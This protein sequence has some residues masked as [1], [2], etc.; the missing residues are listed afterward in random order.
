MLRD[1]VTG[2][3]D[4]DDSEDGTEDRWLHCAVCGT[5]IVRPEAR[6]A[7]SEGLGIQGGAFVNPHGYLHEIEPFG[8]APGARTIGPPH[9]ADSWFPGYV[10]T[11][12]HCRSCGEH[13]G[14]AFDALEG[15]AP[16]RFWG[17]RTASLKA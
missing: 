10:W 17:L 13:L 16:R 11:L 1:E 3:P 4:L 9:R 7:H 15:Q 6:L 14:W 2:D 5:P 12:A 8:S